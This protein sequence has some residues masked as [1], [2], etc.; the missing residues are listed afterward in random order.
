MKYLAWIG[1]VASVLGSF[2]VAAKL[3]LIGYC[4]FLLGSVSWSLVGL[5]RRDMALVSLNVCF[6]TANLFGLYNLGV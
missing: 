6:L 1:T 4:F 2:I 3:F 5:A